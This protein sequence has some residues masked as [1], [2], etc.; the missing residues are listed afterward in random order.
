RWFTGRRFVWID[1][2][3]TPLPLAIK[4]GSQFATL[5]YRER[6]KG[7]FCFSCGKEGHRRGDPECHGR[8]QEKPASTSQDTPAAAETL[9]DVQ[10]SFDSDWVGSET[11][12]KS[13]SESHSSDDASKLVPSVVSSDNKVGGESEKLVKKKKRKNIKKSKKEEREEEDTSQRDGRQVQSKI[14][15]LY[16]TGSSRSTSASRKRGEPPTPD[17]KERP[18]QRPKT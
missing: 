5:F 4:I 3:S 17:E 6:P 13:D 11:D 15:D 18:S 10:Q 14:S 1:L 16:C 12:D 8:Q 9:P 7:V 2:P